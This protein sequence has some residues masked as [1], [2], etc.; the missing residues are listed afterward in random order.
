MPKPGAVRCPLQRWRRTL[1][2]GDPTEDLAEAAVHLDRDSF[3]LFR[4]TR[5]VSAFGKHWRRRPLMCS[6]EGRCQRRVRLAEVHL[7]VGIDLEMHPL[8]M[9]P[10]CHG[11]EGLTGHVGKVGS[12]RDSTSLDACR[13]RSKTLQLRRPR[14][15]RLSGPFWVS[16]RVGVVVWVLGRLLM[17]RPRRRQLA[18]LRSEDVCLV[19]DAVDHGGGDGLAAEGGIINS[20]VAGGPG[21]TP[22]HWRNSGP[23]TKQ[24][25]FV[26]RH[27]YLSQWVSS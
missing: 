3:E 25:G 23:D 4:M 16:G 6:S 8:A 17:H 27:E 13:R 18:P 19:D 7:D 20:K 22:C 2:E 1:C 9:S 24:R 14:S 10:P 5:L 15:E 26:R 12:D 21:L 11:G